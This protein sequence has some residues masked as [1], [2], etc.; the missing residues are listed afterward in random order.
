MSKIGIIARNTGRII[1]DHAPAILTGLSVFG[2]VATAVEA[3]RATPEALRRVTAFENQKNEG[4]QSGEDWVKATPL[5]VVKVAWTAYIPAAAIGG[6]TLACTLSAHGIH[7]KR[8]AAMIAG[9]T[10]VEKAYAE[11]KEQV[12]E[13]VG[14]NKEQE[15]RDKVAQK[16]TDRAVSENREVVLV[17]SGNILCHD[18]ASGRLFQSN[19]EALRK[20]ENDINRQCINEMYASQ[21]EFYEKIGLSGNSYGEQF[22]WNTDNPL[23]LVFT[24]VLVEDKPALSIN[25]R[26]APVSR[27]N[28]LG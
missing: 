25:Y 23:E 9:Y 4:V 19:M 28:R 21:N 10:V 27:F 2:T 13:A 12:V 8:Q 22:G 16:Q 20:A 6:A 11:Y 7:L 24:S 17:G 3:V 5:E 1:K 18:S 14:K 15:I 26:T